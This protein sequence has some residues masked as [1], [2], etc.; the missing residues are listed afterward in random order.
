MIARRW[1]GRWIENAALER[2]P[3][4]QT[5]IVSTDFRHRF[6]AVQELTELLL[7]EQQTCSPK[8]A[9]FVDLYIARLS[10]NNSKVAATGALAAPCPVRRLLCRGCRVCR[11]PCALPAAAERLSAKHVAC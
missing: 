4:I 6:E 1:A 5:K 2:L 10:D 11:V 8:M 7:R 3:S 9:F